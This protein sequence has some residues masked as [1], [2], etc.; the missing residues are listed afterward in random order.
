MFYIFPNVLHLSIF[1]FKKLNKNI[2]LIG[3]CFIF[4]NEVTIICATS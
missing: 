4:G 1:L 2:I 3:I